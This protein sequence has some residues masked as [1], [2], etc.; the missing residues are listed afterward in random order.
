MRLKDVKIGF[1]LTASFCTL[2]EVV[3]HMEKLVQEGAEIYPIMTQTIGSTDTKYGKADEWRTKLEELTGHTIIDNIVAA[4]PIGPGKLVDVIVI[5]PC[6]G[7]T[8]AKLAN[9]ITDGPVLMS[10]KAQL[11]NQRPVVI[12]I[13]TNDGLGLN[14]RNLGTLLNTRNIYMVPFGQDNPKGKPN[15][16]VAKMDL[17]LE[18]IEYALKG[19]QIQ[20]VLAKYD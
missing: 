1:A 2:G 18:T 14:A 19:H 5:A 13:S 16:L 9:G 17:M 20:P 3:K 11:R 15:S 12:A 8:L 10:A 6:T 4:E 7:N